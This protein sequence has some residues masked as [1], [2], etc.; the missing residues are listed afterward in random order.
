MDKGGRDG[1]VEW[2]LLGKGEAAKSMGRQIHLGPTQKK[3]RTL[4]YMEC[5]VGLEIVLA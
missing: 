3:D 2:V 5:K 1:G 4:S